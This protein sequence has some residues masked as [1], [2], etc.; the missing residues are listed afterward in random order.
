MQFNIRPKILQTTKNKSS[1]FEIYKRYH[2]KRYF[3]SYSIYLKRKERQTDISILTGSI[4]K[5][6]SLQLTHL[7][8]IQ[9]PVLFLKSIT[10]ILL[11]YEL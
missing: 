11:T 6:N 10:S 2:V 3:T 5:L 4:Q 8:M 1:N 9:G 7:I